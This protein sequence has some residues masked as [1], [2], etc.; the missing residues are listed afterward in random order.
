MVRTYHPQPAYSDKTINFF[1]VNI[2]LIVPPSWS[3]RFSSPASQLSPHRNCFPHSCPQP[4][5]PPTICLE[6]MPHI[7]K[8][9]MA[10]SNPG[11]I[12][13]KFDTSAGWSSL[14]HSVCMQCSTYCTALCSWKRNYIKHGKLSEHY[15]WAVRS[16]GEGGQSSNHQLTR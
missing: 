6:H 9:G 14:L 7:G 13:D 1:R 15:R 2:P 8:A 10:L 12:G 3:Q 16:R 4:I 5:T 11:K